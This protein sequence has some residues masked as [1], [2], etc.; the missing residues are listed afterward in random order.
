MTN[1]YRLVAIIAGFA[2]AIAGG[3]AHGMEFDWKTDAGVDVSAFATFGFVESQAQFDVS[4]SGR[5][6]ARD[7]SMRR[8]REG[9]QKIRDTAL[10][11]LKAKGYRLAEDGSPDF[12]IGY[13]ALVISTDDPLSMPTNVTG[14][15]RTGGGVKVVR[16]HS[17][18]DEGLLYSGRLSI[19]IVDA[20]SLQIVWVAS[21][22]GSIDELRRQGQDAHD[23]TQQLMAKLPASGS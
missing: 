2:F 14:G 18:W 15:R 9:E 7:R 22:E 4:Q 5:D 17:L 8:F 12:F 23:V 6:A 21:A 16:R 11:A 13:D 1:A 19:F 20:K 10:A 3:A